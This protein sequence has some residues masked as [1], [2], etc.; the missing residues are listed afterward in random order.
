M[1][2]PRI[3]ALLVAAGSAL[4]LGLAGPYAVAGCVAPALAVGRFTPEATTAERVPIRLG[5][6]VTISG[7]WFR[8]G[9]SDAYARSGCSTRP[10]EQESPLT[11]VRLRLVQ[12]GRQWTLGVA[13]AGDRSS[14]YAIH[15]QVRLPATT[16]PGPARLEAGDAVLKVRIRR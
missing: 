8:D 5:R 15:W 14:H 16:T 1:P 13:D 3:T 10:V 6:P 2:T 4:V 7:G 12:G 9:C 11:Q